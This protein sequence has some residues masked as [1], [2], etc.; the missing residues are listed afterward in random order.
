[1]FR[2]K[3]AVPVSYERQGYIYFKS[4][5]YR[6]LPEAEQQRIV[7]LCLASG[8]EYYQAL[9]EFV[10]TDDG[11]TAVCMRHHLSRSTLERV[12]RCYYTNW[13]QEK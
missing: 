12:V 3:K 5:C 2:F 11:A 6:D 7:N 10:T 9:F 4:R 1:M 13:P 8:G